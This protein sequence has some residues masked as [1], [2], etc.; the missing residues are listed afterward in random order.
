[1]NTKS[2]GV[3]TINS[4]I[5]PKGIQRTLEVELYENGNVEIDFTLKG[6]DEKGNSTQQFKCI[7]LNRREAFALIFYLVRTMLP[8]K[9][10]ANK[11]KKEE[12]KEEKEVKKEE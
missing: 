9:F 6:K 7:S 12:R 1:M 10:L 5:T 8:N 4:F 2:S 3:E 11:W